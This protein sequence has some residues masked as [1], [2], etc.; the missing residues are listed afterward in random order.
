MAAATIRASYYGA[1]AGEP[2]G[3]TAETG[4]TFSKSDAQVPAAGTAPVSIPVATGT[5]Y[6]WI[7]LLAFEVT[8]TGTTTINN[9]TVKYASSVTAGSAVFFGNTSTYRQPASGNKPT[10]SGSNG[11]ATPTPAGSNAPGSYTALT[12]S[13]QQWDNTSTVT[14][15]TGRKGNFCELVYGVDFTYAG[16]G[17]QEALPNLTMQYD[18]F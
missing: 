16:G 7:M 17:G 10:D 8:G 2:A 18:E 15:S 13:A 1:S 9:R 6:S 14:S 12:T 4:I 5:N 3:V 11:P